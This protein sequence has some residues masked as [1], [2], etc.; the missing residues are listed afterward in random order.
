MFPDRETPRNPLRPGRNR[1]GWKGPLITLWTHPVGAMAKRQKGVVPSKP[2]EASAQ[3]DPAG[4][5]GDGGEHA[6]RAVETQFWQA[7]T[8]AE[9]AGSAWEAEAAP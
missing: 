6:P 4:E 3:N 7:M 5:E 8:P 1:P 9:V 2:M